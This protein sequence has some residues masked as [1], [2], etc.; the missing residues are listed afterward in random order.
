MK[1]GECNKRGDND[2]ITSSSTF[3]GL[4]GKNNKQTVT[5]TDSKTKDDACEKHIEMNNAVE[6]HDLM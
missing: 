4:E 1:R 2:G 3:A 6:N 5:M